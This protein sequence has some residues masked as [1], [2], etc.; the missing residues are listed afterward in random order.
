MGVSPVFDD[1]EIKSHKG[2][3]VVKF[4]G[5]TPFN[6]K[7]IIETGMHFIV[8]NRVSELY[9][10]KLS[11]IL[12]GSATMTILATE[13]NKSLDKF[14]DYVEKLVSQGVR[15]GHT[16]VAIGGGT[17]QD[18]VCFLAATLLRG[19]DWLFI[20][21][22]LLAQSD[23]CIGSKSSVNVGTI[24][25]IL[26]TYTPPKRILIYGEFISTLADSDVMSGIGEMLKVHAIDSPD[27]FNTIAGDY[28]KLRSNPDLLEHYVYSSL[29]IKQ[30]LIELD[31]FDRGPRNVMNYGHSFGH[32]LESATN[33]QIPHGIAVTIGMDIAN[34]VSAQY[35]M[36][37]ET[38]FARRH[39]VLRANWSG[40]EN[41]A[42]PLTPFFQALSKDKKNTDTQLKLV[43]PDKSAK[44]VI[45]GFEMGPR[46]M[47][48]CE[49]YFNRAHKR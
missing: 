38:D 27:S 26:G 8:D 12:G 15:R 14:P 37:S 9:R 21:T 43:L 22:T 7:D 32:A 47:K 45:S 30:R 44:I 10:D 20:P 19:L 29:K 2:V 23:S 35:A 46:F 24:K 49:S 18:I 33:Y 3:Y 39:T 40:Y 1:L 36:L 42:I 31:E 41:V 6:G 48:I 4:Q 16:L 17:T 13:E 5:D 28:K 34:Y 25:N 11:N